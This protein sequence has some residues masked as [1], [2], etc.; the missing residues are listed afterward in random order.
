M[1]LV[2][3]PTGLYIVVSYQA[4][5]VL[6]PWGWVNIVGCRKH[7]TGHKSTKPLLSLAKHRFVVAYRAL[8]R[9][10]NADDMMLVAAVKGLRV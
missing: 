5:Y 6:Q 9:K 2:C 3:P 10:F 1:C 8:W 4:W 7:Q